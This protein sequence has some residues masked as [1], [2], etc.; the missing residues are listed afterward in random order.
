MSVEKEEKALAIL[1]RLRENGFIALFN[2]GCVRD[3]VLGVAVKDYDIATDARPEVVQRL[4]DNTVAVGA[5]FGVIMV[6]IDGDAVRGRHLS[7]RRA[8]C[9]WPPSVVGALRHD[10]GGRRAPRLHHRRNVLRPCRGSP[11]RTG[12]R[13]ARFARRDDPRD[14]KSRRALSRRI[15]CACCARRVSPRASISRSSPRPWAAMRR[16]APMVAKISAER[17]GEEIVTTD[18]RGRRRARHGHDGRERPDAKWCCPKC[19]R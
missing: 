12:R 2:G 18:D 13:D 16:A 10:R 1:G 9:R 4:F 8:L 5:Q 14:R 11:D 19:S 3:R 17:I 7:R 15:I 6:I